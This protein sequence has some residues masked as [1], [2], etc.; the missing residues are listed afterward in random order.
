MQDNDLTLLPATDA[1]EDAG[2]RLDFFTVVLRSAPMSCVERIVSRA[3]GSPARS[4]E[5]RWGNR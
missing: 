3:P 1:E 2:V 5:R 4:R